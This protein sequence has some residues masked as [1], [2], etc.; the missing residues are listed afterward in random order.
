M[1][2]HEGL[3][4]IRTRLIHDPS[5]EN[6]VGLGGTLVGLL[7][8][9]VGTMAITSSNNVEGHHW[10][11]GRRG[12]NQ[13]GDDLIVV[14]VGVG[15]PLLLHRITIVSITVITDGTTAR[16]PPCVHIRVGV[17]VGVRRPRVSGC[18]WQGRRPLLPWGGRPRK[19]RRG[20][21]AQLL[22]CGGNPGAH[23]G[24]GGRCGWQGRRLA[25]GGPVGMPMSGTHSGCSGEQETECVKDVHARACVRGL[26]KNDGD[27]TGV[28]ERARQRDRAQL[29]VGRRERT[30]SA[31]GLRSNSV[32]SDWC[33]MKKMRHA[34]R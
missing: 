4:W 18:G 12:G 17:R 20:W 32:N 31:Q 21:Q 19:V 34:D 22:P 10:L 8:A 14:F 6:A 15:F 13:I 23:H 3:H 1:T 27:C 5:A 29:K 30:R 28:R 33:H 24:C 11:I 26:I 16:P 7:D 2:Y 9:R 25:L